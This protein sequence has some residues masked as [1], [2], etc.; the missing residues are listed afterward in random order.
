MGRGFHLKHSARLSPPPGGR[1]I[2]EELEALPSW[3]LPRGPRRE[4]PTSLPHWARGCF[5]PGMGRR[6]GPT[7]ALSL[8]RHVSETGASCPGCRHSPACLRGWQTPGLGCCQAWPAVLSPG[9]PTLGARGPGPQGQA[10]GT[11][12]SCTL[13]S[14]GHKRGVCWLLLPQEQRDTPASDVIRSPKCPSST[15]L[16]APA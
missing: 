9:R 13:C 10:C 1:A 6:A 4:T 16:L 7:W 15:H 14:T 11:R 5:V 2:S 8:L 3:P 12:P